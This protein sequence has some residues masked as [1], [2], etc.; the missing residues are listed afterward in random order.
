MPILHILVNPVFSQHNKVTWKEVLTH[1][2]STHHRPSFLLSSALLCAPTSEEHDPLFPKVLS[3][4]H[5]H[6]LPFPNCHQFKTVRSQLHVKVGTLR[7]SIKPQCWKRVPFLK[8]PWPIWPSNNS[9]WLFLPL[10]VLL[11]SHVVKTLLFPPANSDLFFSVEY[12]TFLSASSS[13]LASPNGPFSSQN[14]LLRQ[15]VS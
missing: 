2:S 14:G 10:W 7:H 15:L 8:V 1:A 11:H 13:S 5:I 6:T 12:F 9:L 3:S 4:G